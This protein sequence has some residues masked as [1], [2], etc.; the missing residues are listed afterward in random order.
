M[1]NIVKID[2]YKN[3]SIALATD[4]KLYVW[5][6]GFASL[7]M[8][9]IS[10]EQIVDISGNLVLTESGTVYTLTNLETKIDGMTNIVKISA[11]EAHNLAVDVNS[12]L[13]AWGTN[14]NGECGVS[15]TGTIQAKKIMFD[16]SDISAGN[17]M[18]IV[19]DNAGEVYVFGNNANGQIG[20][21]TTTKATTPT[22]LTISED[23]NIEVISARRRNT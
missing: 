1:S 13:Y 8:R 23:V 6:Q 4:G 22:K 7:P 14:T 16:V 12:V 10:K 5:G 11:G 3:I 20:L 19:K 2:A 17:G 15:T 18:S 9:K 21:N